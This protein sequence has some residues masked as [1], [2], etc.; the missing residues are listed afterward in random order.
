MWGKGEK[1]KCERRGISQGP[2]NYMRQREGGKRKCFLSNN[3]GE[4][5]VNRGL[6]E[7]R[8]SP[9]AS[10]Q[11]CRWLLL[12]SEAREGAVGVCSPTQGEAT[13]KLGCILLKSRPANMGGS[14]GAQEF[15]D[16]TGFLI[17]ISEVFGRIEFLS[18][19]TSNSVGC[20]SLT[21]RW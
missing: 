14:E 3:G 8:C 10:C 11:C 4:N 1:L 18:L 2:C 13:K 9:C 12:L 20:I 16:I 6:W 17:L 21:L 19:K 15:T 5:A 7:G